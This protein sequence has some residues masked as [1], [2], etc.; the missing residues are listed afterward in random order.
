MDESLWFSVRE[1][2]AELPETVEASQQAEQVGRDNRPT[3]LLDYG[4]YFDLALVSP[5]V[6]ELAPSE[7][8][9]AIAHLRR[10]LPLS[11]LL[12]PVEMPPRIRNFSTDY[13]SA[14][15]L[16]QMVR[17]WDIEPANRMAMTAA[18][19]EEFARLDSQIPVAMHWLRKAAPELYGEVEII[20]RDIVLSRP[21][22]TNLI[23]YSGASSFA[24]WGALTINAETQREWAQL[25]RQI[26]HEAGHNLLFGIAREQPLVL[27]DPA[28]RRISPIRADP[29]PMDGIFH[30]AFVSA[31]EAYAFEALLNFN[32]DADALSDD[33][34][35]IFEDLLELSVLAFWNGVETLRSEANL[36]ELGAKILDDCEEYMVANFAVVPC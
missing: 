29:R 21:D 32:E 16:G 14:G 22:G 6:A 15:Q 17:W 26:V 27:D 23:N 30:A 28:E 12:E 9:A 20:V 36:T 25:Y 1:L 5:V 18:S 19:K 7:K 13:F 3:D 34:V 4:A 8:Q 11:D 33:D 31:R 24:L 10:R 35:Q 2:L